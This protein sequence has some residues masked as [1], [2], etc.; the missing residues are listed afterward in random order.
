MTLDQL[1][2][3]QKDVLLEQIEPDG[4]ADIGCGTVLFRITTTA[5]RKPIGD[6]KVLNAGYVLAVRTAPSGQAP[7]VYVLALTAGGYAKIESFARADLEPGS[8]KALFR[9]KPLPAGDPRGATIDWIGRLTKQENDA[10]TD[11]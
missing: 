4:L 10:N 6:R 9:T 5:G 1:K 8:N 11:M 7:N 3:A 2:A